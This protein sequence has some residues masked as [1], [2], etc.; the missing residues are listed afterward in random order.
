MATTKEQLLK[1]LKGIL[2]KYGHV[3][4]K[5][6]LDMKTDLIRGLGLNEI[7]FSVIIVEIYECFQDAIPED[8]IYTYPESHSRVDQL[9][10]WMYR[11]TSKK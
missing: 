7:E 10:D 3:K 9:I 8:E 5:A 11:W 1:V 2:V 6:D 4:E